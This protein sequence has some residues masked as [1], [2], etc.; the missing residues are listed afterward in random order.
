MEKLAA[1]LSLDLDN[2][3]SYMKVHGD[4]GWE[5]YPT[6]LPEVVPTILDFFKEHDQKITFMI[7]GADAT[8]SEN[9][10]ALQMI[11]EA[12]HEIGNHSFNHEP[13]MQ[14]YDQEKVEEELI[15]AAE[16][17]EQ[18]CGV[19]TTGF[20]GPGY[21]MSK[22]MLT[23]LKRLDYQYDASSFPSILGPV[24]RLYY[25]AT[26]KFNKTEKEDR[27]D[28]FGHFS[29]GFQ[30]IKAYQWETQEGPILEIPVTTIPCFRT[31]FHLSYL[32][33]LSRFST[34][35]ATAYM[36][37]AFTMCRLCR[38]QPSFLL[39]PLDF[40]GPDQAPQLRFFPG[41]E[42]SLEHKL[43]FASKFLR[44]FQKHFNVQ[45]MEQHASSIRK[46]KSVKS[47]QASYAQ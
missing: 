44:E 28:L 19:K 26:K 38:V 11:A 47:I 36:K 8:R 42:L 39:H 16:A 34:L 25:M 24:A 17:I 40:I 29:D 37:F 10:Q 45:T 13:W 18:A 7:V 14:N 2:L 20:R 22:N 33:W 1:S 23:A 4:P 21:S 32:I 9:K 31:P 15:Q 43:N 27:A 35:L 30:P 6:Y 3:W 46:Q 5:E 12:G 41:M